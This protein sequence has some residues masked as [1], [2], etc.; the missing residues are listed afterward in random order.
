MGNQIAPI[1]VDYSEANTLG[2]SLGLPHLYGVINN[3][4]LSGTIFNRVLFPGLTIKKK[5][6]LMRKY[7]DESPIVPPWGQRRMKRSAQTSTE[8][9]RAQKEDELM[10][11]KTKNSSRWKTVFN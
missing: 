3:E 2:N 11:G 10:R 5:R 4:I 7:P 8:I 9:A 1:G 6:S